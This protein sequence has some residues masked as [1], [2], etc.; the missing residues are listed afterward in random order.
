MQPL[1]GAPP[2]PPTP[3]PGTGPM[4]Q[5]PPASRAGAPGRQERPPG[6][7]KFGFHC[8]YPW[9]R[10]LLSGQKTVET[11]GYQLPVMYENQDI[12]IIETPGPTGRRKNVRRGIIGTI[13]F[14]HCFEYASEEEWLQDQARHLIEPGDQQLGWKAGRRRLGWTVIGT[15]ALEPKMKEW[16]SSLKTEPQ[17]KCFQRFMW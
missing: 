16:M 5:M 14:G 2:L 13:R 4:P 15:K 6:M 10:Y 1:P 3:H 12:A 8:Q 9:S 11:R 7:P 17:Y